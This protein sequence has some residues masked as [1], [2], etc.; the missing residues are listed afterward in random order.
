MSMRNVND[1]RRNGLF[2]PFEPVL[3]PRAYRRILKGW[4][5]TFRHVILK[6]MPMEVMAVTGQLPDEYTRD[7]VRGVYPPPA[8]PIRPGN[9]ALDIARR[10]D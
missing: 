4:Q 5:G 10:V 6:P 1:P 9:A 8:G 2:D 3:S 7:I